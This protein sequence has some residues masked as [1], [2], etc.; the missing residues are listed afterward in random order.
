MEKKSSG[1]T[2]YHKSRHRDLGRVPAT[3]IV[4]YGADKRNMLGWH[5]TC[6]LH[7]IRYMG[8]GGICGVAMGLA[9]PTAC[10]AR[11]ARMQLFLC[12]P[13]AA[14]PLR[15]AL[16]LLDGRYG[17][18]VGCQPAGEAEL[19]C[20]CRAGPGPL[21]LRS[22][23]QAALACPRSSRHTAAPQRAVHGLR[24]AQ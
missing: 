18:A 5:E 1:G 8:Q 16:S 7:M 15:A 19:R 6:V 12:A 2:A 3:Q 4:Q 22:S 23:Q 11:R 10:K 20:S 14:L 17:A 24:G 21:L 13:V 9:R